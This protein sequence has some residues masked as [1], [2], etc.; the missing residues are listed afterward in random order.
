M[1]MLLGGMDREPNADDKTHVTSS[2]LSCAYT[3]F[4]PFENTLSSI[5]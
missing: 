5:P 4:K 1:E 2:T 3:H